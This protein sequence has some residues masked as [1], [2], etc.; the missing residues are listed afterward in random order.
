MADDLVSS[1]EENV[2]VASTSQL[3]LQ[4]RKRMR[5]RQLSVGLPPLSQTSLT[6][7]CD[8]GTF[9]GNEGAV[10]RDEGTVTGSETGVRKQSQQ[11]EQLSWE[12]AQLL[13][14]KERIE[15]QFYQ[16]ASDMKTVQD[17]S[18]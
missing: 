18:K 17:E 10:S 8:E 15:Q 12:M 7:S 4:F 3:L 16:V 1:A 9:T 6:C 2:V 5:C 14:L 13:Q 11:L